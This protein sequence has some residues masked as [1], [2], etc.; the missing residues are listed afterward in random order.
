MTVYMQLLNAIMLNEIKMKYNMQITTR[1]KLAT[2]AN[3]TSLIKDA[4]LIL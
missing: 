1:A 4:N 3:A 2:N